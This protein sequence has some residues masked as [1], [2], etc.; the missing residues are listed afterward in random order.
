VHFLRPLY[1]SFFPLNPV[2]TQF[3]SQAQKLKGSRP[4][5]PNTMNL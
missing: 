4:K 2:W 5:E 3:G 1:G